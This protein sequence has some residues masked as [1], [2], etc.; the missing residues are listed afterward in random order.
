M[1]TTKLQPFNK[2]TK[3]NYEKGIFKTINFKNDYDEKL[4]KI[5][6]FFEQNI[7]LK[8]YSFINSKIGEMWFYS[9]CELENLMKVHCFNSC[10]T[11]DSQ[12]VN[13]LTQNDK[14]CLSNC[15]NET[16]YLLDGVKKFNYL[17]FSN[18]LNDNTYS[19]ENSI[20]LKRI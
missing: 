19:L 13:N 8:E 2:N 6:L 10:Y 4:L 20:P 15:A 14:L 16:S 18:Q 17:L 7:F 11:D 12:N 5:K 3:Y 9:K 1:S